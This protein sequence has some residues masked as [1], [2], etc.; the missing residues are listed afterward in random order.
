[1]T[2]ER[3]QLC[4]RNDG[5][6]REGRLGRYSLTCEACEQRRGSHLSARPSG[7]DAIDRLPS[8]QWARTSPGWASTVLEPVGRT[9]RRW[10]PRAIE[11]VV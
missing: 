7:Y 1:M 6:Q 8:M 9:R 4:L 2:P 11:R 10:R 3:C 5:V